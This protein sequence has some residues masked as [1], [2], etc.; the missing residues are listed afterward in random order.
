M[1]SPKLIVAF[2]KTTLGAEPVREWLQA[3][4]AIDRKIMGEDIKT[5]QYG[6]PLG[7]PLVRKMAAHLWEVRVNL[8]NRIARVLFTLD[9]VHMV[10]LHGFIKKSPQTPTEDLK[11]AQTRLKQFRSTL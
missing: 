8:P 10:L 6:W 3:L 1:H 2:F 11:L 4:D 7:M 5:V 9:G